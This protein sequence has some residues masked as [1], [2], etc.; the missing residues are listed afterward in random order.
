MRTLFLS[1]F[2]ALTAL[3]ALSQAGLG[4]TGVN[5]QIPSSIREEHAH[6][7]EMLGKAITEQG[8]LGDA[9]RAL[10][11]VLHPHFQREEEIALPPLALLQRLSEGLAASDEESRVVRGMAGALESELPR[12]LEEHGLIQNALAQFRAE[13]ENA[14]RVEYVEFA[15]KLALHAR[16]EEEILY[17]AAILVG[18]YLKE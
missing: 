10:M 15:D 4:E 6:L 2:I 16:Q 9:A 13:A 14:G 3:T 7:H 11:N 1:G 17:P 18:K 5:L 12:M 8:K